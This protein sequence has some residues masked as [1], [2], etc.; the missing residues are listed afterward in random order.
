[1]ASKNKATSLPTTAVLALLAACGFD[2][3][4]DWPKT[5][6]LSRAA[7]IGKKVLPADVPA[8]HKGTYDALVACKGSLN[9]TDGDGE[10][11]ADPKPAKGKKAAKADGADPKPAKGKKAAKADDSEAPPAK[12][13]NA[14]GGVA[15]SVY[16]R[17]MELM[18]DKKERTCQEVADELGL[19]VDQV[20]LRLYRGSKTGLLQHRRE[21]TFKFV[22]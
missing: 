12:K 3:A 15:G 22:G 11:G 9:L 17:V 20:R 2:D 10:P 14:Y 19:A 1:M 8:E 16:S 5:T 21:I 13:K 4:K 7:K 6:L 18:A